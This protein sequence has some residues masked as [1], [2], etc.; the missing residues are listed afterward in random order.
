MR[1]SDGERPSG[2][3]HGK[4][5][6][7]ARLAEVL[8]EA[9]GEEEE[10]GPTSVE[11]AEVLW[12]ARQMKASKPATA[13]P[14]LPSTPRT[15]QDTA[16]V[17][18][19]RS[20]DAQ[21]PHEPALV[22]PEPR[23]PLHIPDDARQPLD[24]PPPDGT[25]DGS[26]DDGTYT[27]LLAPAPPMLPRPLTLQRALRPL[28]RRVP[29]PVGIELDESATADRIARLAAPP[30]WWLPV[31]RPSAERWLRLRIVYDEGPTMPIWRPLLRELRTV[32]GQ[33]GIFR[34][35]D[36]HTLTAD[37]HVRGAEG[38][39][40]DG[41]T[42]TLVVSDCMGP[43]WRG[44][45]AGRRWYGTLNRWASRHPVAIVQPLPERL[46]RTTALPAAATVL[47]AP[48]PAAPNSAYSSGDRDTVTIPVLEPSAPWL[49]HWS[50]LV[51]GAGPVPCAAAL[52]ARTPP[53]SPLEETGSTDV[54]QLSASDLLLRFKS[55]ASPEAYRLAGHLA[56]GRPHLPYMRLVQAAL[57]R[58][59]QPGHLAE[60]VLSGLLRTVPGAAPGSY[61][62]RDGVRELLLDTLPRSS[63]LRTRGL[64]AR[65][66]APIDDRAGVVAGELRVAVEGGTERGGVGAEV[67]SVRGESV[68]RL[69]G[70]AREETRPARPADEEL[71]AGRYKVLRPVDPVLRRTWLAQDFETE[72]LVGL[73][74]FLNTPPH[75]KAGEAF[76]LR[77]ESLASVEH[78]NVVGLHDHGFEGD[79]AYAALEYV[80]GISVA[81]LVQDSEGPLPFWLVAYLARGTALA[82]AAA[83]EHH[84]AHGELAPEHVLIDADGT[85]RVTGFLDGIAAPN[86]AGDSLQVENMVRNLTRDSSF[87]A[88]SLSDWGSFAGMLPVDPPGGRDA[89]SVL[90][91]AD[92]VAFEQ[93]ALAARPQFQLLDI[94]LCPGGWLLS[95]EARAC[96]AMLLQRHGRTV[97]LEELSEGLGGEPADGWRR[98]IDELRSRLGPGVI[99][100]TPG[101]FAVH[102]LPSQIDA[103]QVNELVRS[104]TAAEEDGYP[105]RARS[106]VQSALDLF[107]GDPLSGVPGPAAERTR[108]RLRRLRL[109]L[110]AHR[111]ELQL[112]I[113]AFERAAT[114]LTQLLTEHP[115]R[116]D[117]RRLHML[118]LRN[119]GR[120][121]DAIES[122]EQYRERLEDSHPDP[123]LVNL[124]DELYR[125]LLAAPERDRA[126]AVF[127][128]LTDS[129]EDNERAQA[130]VGRYVTDVLSRARITPDSHELLA[131][132]NG[133]VVIADPDVSLLPLLQT[134]LHEINVLR[135]QL[136]PHVRLR[137]MFW[138][139]AELIGHQ[140]PDSLRAEFD[141]A[142]GQ[143]L[144]IISPLLHE[145]A[146]TGPIPLMRG[147]FTPLAPQGKVI[148]YLRPIWDAPDPALFDTLTND[149]QGTPPS[150]PPLPPGPH[151]DLLRGP[152]T[153][154]GTDL[155]EVND[156]TTAVVYVDTGDEGEGGSVG[157]QR[158]SPYD[159]DDDAV[160]HYYEVDLTPQQEWREL[161]LPSAESLP[162]TASVELSWHVV[163]PFAFV[164][165]EVTHVATEL[166]EH[167]A[168]RLSAVTRRYTLAR[169]GAAQQAVD[170][171]RFAPWPT[172]GLEVSCAVRLSTTGPG[173]PVGATGFLEIDFSGSQPPK[174]GLRLGQVAQ[175]DRP[176][177]A[178]APERD[179][180][181]PTPS[182]V[183]ALLAA[184]R[185]VLIGFDGPVLRLYAQETA[186]SASR[187]LARLITE[188][189][190]PDE[191]LRGERLLKDTPIR[192]SEG[193]AH[194]YDLLR[195]IAHHRLAVPVAERLTVLELRA[196]ASARPTPHADLLIR[197]LH[198]QGRAVGI[199]TD[200]APV[201]ADTYL[202]SHGLGGHLRAGVHGRTA[203]LTHLLPHPDCLR[204]A[205]T[206][207]GAAAQAAL[208]ITSS[209]AALE[210]AAA[211]S[212]PAIGY[213][214][215][216]RTRT[217]LESG[218]STLVV[219][220]LATVLEAA[221]TTGPIARPEPPSP[222]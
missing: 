127:E 30:Q 158:Q 85:V 118:A 45:P 177:T 90:T 146:M 172:S 65:L 3:S 221:R 50:S 16:P 145:E 189:R 119:L 175:P 86:P 120:I 147:T 8:T 222:A 207:T 178:T 98:Y 32:F 196:A 104:A 44:G 7:V 49:A 58:R 114:E 33:S 123:D 203:D 152:F 11:L 18:P 31:L 63:R 159:F 54:Q 60:V 103:L 195:A 128:F 73:L 149:Q 124:H 117:F 81:Q 167:V 129:P 22:S 46:W 121:S 26:S 36:V 48:W 219:D 59:P 183:A 151:R 35:L 144:L 39:P 156:A 165:A 57:E 206:A 100:T 55:I 105:E 174:S 13:A 179:S 20:G 154:R 201:V 10:D 111:A 82:L 56:V 200:A 214:R 19:P 216:D 64:L 141:P 23:V 164:D 199:V 157:V 41:R 210:A 139:N 125:E 190:H 78:P 130:V 217:R 67:A 110:Y 182:S 148:A 38:T 191:A 194:P 160:T 28:K 153:A 15:S 69:G 192:P 166:F 140:G 43:Q 72:R 185:T 205:L 135:G 107:T 77:A 99:A 53:P 133:Y 186:S 173:A 116:Q 6:Y 79:I 24:E 184:A 198:A 176:P 109:Q 34:T 62:F 51:A 40:A 61:A 25:S 136:P 91:S 101:G 4:G 162:V 180:P 143:A 1:G 9:G 52:L 17:S 42:V 163:N 84:V 80:D 2:P 161:P 21:P 88:G 71:F 208:L 169:L 126:T 5:S 112:E 113:G 137:V 181:P 171:L 12:L 212:M 211:L 188:L 170:G 92:F 106:L 27:T 213:A 102:A 87:L 218:G 95:G 37:G 193:Y 68:E 204:R 93:S 115:D 197:T 74:R 96:L 187:E 138:H 168:R 47:S 14:T 97:P 202:D 131:R 132:T 75:S 108:P 122:Y 134:V 155:P 83:H 89:I 215:D 209:R 94:Q 142:E 29:A 220:S 70:P 150:A 66:G 76:R